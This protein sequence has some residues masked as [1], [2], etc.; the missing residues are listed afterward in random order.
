MPSLHAYLE[1]IDARRYAEYQ[2]AI[3]AFLESEA[4]RRFSA[5]WFAGIVS[6]RLAADLAG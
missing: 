5:E 3:L 6:E 4:A 1:A 2:E